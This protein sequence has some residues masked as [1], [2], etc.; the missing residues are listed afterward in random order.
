MLLISKKL[1]LGRPRSQL[2]LQVDPF[3]IM[4]SQRTLDPVPSTDEREFITINKGLLKKFLTHAMILR[5]RPT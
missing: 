3:P 5:C 4:P 2:D 1:A